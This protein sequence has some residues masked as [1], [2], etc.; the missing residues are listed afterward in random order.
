[1]AEEPDKFFYSATRSSNRGTVYLKIVNL[2]A[3]PETV[4]IEINGVKKV[5][6]RGSLLVLTSGQ[7]EDTNTQE[8]PNKV[9]PVTTKIKGLSTSFIRTFAPYSINV[10]QLETQ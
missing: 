4:D 9:V 10:L 2:N 5:A 7:P 1:M 8:D 6:R 3:T